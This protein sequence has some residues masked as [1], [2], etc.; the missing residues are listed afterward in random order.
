MPG[1]PSDH[2]QRATLADEVHA[3]PPMPLATP[4]RVSYLA[5][6][7][8]SDARGPE[9]QHLAVLCKRH[10]VAAPGPQDTHLRVTLG[11][12]QLKWERHGEFSGYTFSA[13]GVPDEPFAGTALDLLAPGWLETIPGRT[14]A[15][16]HAEVTAPGFATP[17]ARSLAQRFV[18]STVVGAEI[19][20]GAARVHTDFRLQGDGCTRLW[21]I[22]R[23][24]TEPQTGRMLQRL[25]EIEAYRVLALLALP[26]ARRQGPRIAAIEEALAR[27]TDGMAQDNAGAKDETLL[28][29]LMRMAAEVESGIA[30][31]QFRFGACEAYY[32]LVQ[33]RAARNE[34]ARFADDRRI[35]EPPPGPGRCH[36]CQRGAAAEKPGRA[37]RADQHLARHPRG[38]GA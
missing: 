21:L 28:H 19:A 26:I 38:R 31:S 30:A 37:H 5:V 12:L 33:R 24:L 27:L 15:A 9:V 25:F 7:V 16:V 10:G 1:F 6:L 36:L 29:E 11:E 20:E 3:R 18:G 34:A 4:S 14:V 35:H 22:N 17:D 13:A 2:P 32:G 8:D 23:Q